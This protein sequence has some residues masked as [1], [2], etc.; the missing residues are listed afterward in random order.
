M[1]NN[2]QIR[3]ARSEDAFAIA[4]ILL[5]CV[6]HIRMEVPDLVVKQRVIPNFKLCFL[7][8]SHSIYVAEE[9]GVVI[10]YISIH[11][12]PYLFFKG[13]EGYISELYVSVNK[14]G[15]G[16]GTSL[17]KKA[18]EDAIA[19]KCIRLSLLNDK[20]Q[21]SYKRGFYKKNGWEERTDMANLVCW[22][23]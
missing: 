20:N 23:K 15:R 11:W 16:V 7:D 13:P 3:K 10:G 22:I 21:D 8:D 1:A 19:R 17:L 4:H 12:L 9:S 18:I 14:R 5:D 6:P 2:F